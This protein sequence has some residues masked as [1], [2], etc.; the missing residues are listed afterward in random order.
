MFKVAW[1]DPEEPDKGFKY[2]Y[3][4]TED[5]SKVASLNSVRAILIEDEGEPRYKITDII[6]KTEGLGVENLRYAGLIAGETSQA[7]EEIVTISMVTCRTIGIGSYLVR[8]GQR[9]IQIDNSH[10]ILTGYA[11]LNKLLGR[12]VYASNNQLGGVQ[13]MYN[14]GVTHKTEAVDL[15][16]V[17]TILDWLSYIPAYIGCDLP[18][19]LPNDPIDRP[20][21]FMPTKSPYDPRCMLAGRINPGKLNC[22]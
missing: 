3:L 7:Y 6:G 2:L 13:I 20:V 16:G 10:I 4:T 8:L 18:I 5:Y 1:E 19:V 21:D 22:Y 14:N 9:V 12:K 15:N 17:Y 11:A